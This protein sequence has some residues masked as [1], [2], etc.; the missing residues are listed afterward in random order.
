MGIITIQQEPTRGPPGAHRLPGRHQGLTGHQDAT[1]TPPGRHQEL[2]R[3]R[4]ATRTRTS[5][6]PEGSKAHARSYLGNVATG[7]TRTTTRER[8]G[9]PPGRR[10]PGRRWHPDTETLQPAGN[11]KTREMGQL[12]HFE[13]TRNTSRL[14]FA[15]LRKLSSSPVSTLQTA[16]TIHPISSRLGAW[17]YHQDAPSSAPR[18]TTGTTTTRTTTAGHL[19]LV[20]G[21][22]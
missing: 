6:P 16:E 13:D 5:W 20:L 11:T 4:P 10:R 19:R 9:R 17:S 2:A 3:G 22:R 1:R 7:A 14:A 18:T 8:P 21:S 12:V 15:R